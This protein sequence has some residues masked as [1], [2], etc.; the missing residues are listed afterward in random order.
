MTFACVIFPFL[1]GGAFIEAL[2]PDKY[3][4]QMPPFPFLFV[5]TFNKTDQY[6]FKMT[7]GPLVLYLEV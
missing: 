3:L 2:I 6:P 5:G 1:F 7:A 4:M